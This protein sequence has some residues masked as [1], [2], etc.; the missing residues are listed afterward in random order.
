MSTFLDRVVLEKQAELARKKE[1]LP[2]AELE[3]ALPHEMP[4]DFAGA[5]R[6][7]GRIIAEIK[8][9]S[10]SVPSFRQGGDPEKLA[11][12]YEESGA[13]AISIVTDTRNF[14]TSLADVTR[15]R[16]LSRLP[17]LVKEFV[18]D[19]YQVIE[20]RTAGADALLLI[21]RLLSSRDLVVLHEHI[22]ALGMAALVECHDSDD[23][24]KA[25]DAGATVI[26]INN[27]NLAT[28]D[29]SLDTARRLLPLIPEG[30]V[31]VAE[32]GIDDHAQIAELSTLGADAFLIGGSLL[33][34]DDP[35]KKLAELLGV[36]P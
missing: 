26:G 27:R 9:K 23:V 33:Q 34:S 8:K 36:A 4:R 12:V 29:V 7:G 13:A 28:L 22:E 1:M 18:I 20:A 2:E 10:P 14:G 21:A 25:V 17:V 31:R 30:A 16:N 19:T 6:G 3:R 5:I 24:N 15:V 35:G 11:A 32:S